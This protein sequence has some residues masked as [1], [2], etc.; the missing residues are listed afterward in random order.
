MTAVQQSKKVSFS[1]AS[2][3]G[4]NVALESTT[5]HYIVG[6]E[7]TALIPEIGMFVTNGETKQVSHNH[8]VLEQPPGLTVIQQVYSNASQRYSNSRD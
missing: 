2:K 3:T 5:G 8:A 6:G 1:E 4:V 7:V